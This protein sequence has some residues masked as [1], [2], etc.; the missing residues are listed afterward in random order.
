MDQAEAL[1][2]L[3]THVDTCP[4][5][6]Q[7]GRVVAVI[8]AQRGV[9]V[10]TTSVNLSIALTRQQASVALI[11]ADFEQPEA[12]RQCG[13]TSLY[14]L[15]DLLEGRRAIREIQQVG[16]AGVTLLPGH[17]IDFDPS[18][19]RVAPITQRLTSLADWVVIDSGRRLAFPEL[20]RQVDDV[21]VVT[22][23]RPESVL[24]AYAIVKQTVS[25]QT[26]ARFWLI[27]SQTDDMSRAED[28]QNR[29][30]IVCD[31]FL[32][33][34]I[35]AAANIPVDGCV[36]EADRMNRPVLLHSPASPMSLALDTL[37]S[38]LAR[39]GTQIKSALACVSPA[40]GPM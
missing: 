32:N 38:K 14:T 26:A 8:G 13:L 7:P 40:D 18:L 2:K 1:R 21:I 4:D 31:R 37:A 29:V 15:K 27:V 25:H 36:R 39:A 10:T 9:G 23:S 17:P 22:T 12:A 19:H 6:C 24:E 33:L 11:D 34:P 28:A 3:A 20:H 30:A 16:P 35:H 5:S